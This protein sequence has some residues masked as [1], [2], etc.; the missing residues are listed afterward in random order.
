MNK[1]PVIPERP[2]VPPK[3]VELTEEEKKERIAK[4][5]LRSLER[6]REAY[7]HGNSADNY[8]QLAKLAHV[9]AQEMA[10]RNNGTS[11]LAGYQRKT[12]KK[13]RKRHNSR[14]KP[15]K[16]RTRRMRRH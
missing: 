12:S 11:N 4:S 7:G 15:R 16:H 10:K 5:K 13:S 6:D 14:K 9:T 2:T 8:N 1:L 3:F